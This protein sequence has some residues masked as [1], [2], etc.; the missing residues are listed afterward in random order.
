LLRAIRFNMSRS[1]DGLLHFAELRDD[2][3]EIE[4]VDMSAVVEDVLAQLMK[5]IIDRGVR[6]DV[7]PDLPDAMGHTPWVE[8]VLANLIS[9]AV[10]YIGQDNPDP[11]IMIRGSLQGDWVR[12][13][14]E[15]NG[16]GIAP[17]DQEQLF[18]AFTRFHKGE[19][20]GHGLGLSIVKSIIHKLNGE[21]GVESVLGEGS[22]FWFTLPAPPP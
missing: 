6:I 5:L 22:T 17:E 9:N 11:L 15:D 18:E 1:I 13:E 8:E 16:V 7:A 4:E 3:G 19:A 2:Q 12:F 20:S 10:K 14:I 21:L